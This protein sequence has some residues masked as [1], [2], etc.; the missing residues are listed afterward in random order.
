MLRSKLK[1]DAVYFFLLLPV[2]AGVGAIIYFS[3][4]FEPAWIPLLSMLCI[5]TILRIA[6]RKQFAAA[7]GVTLAIALLAGFVVGKWETERRATPMLGSDV[8]TRV[9][10]GLSLLNIRTMA[11]GG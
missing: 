1:R 2:F 10:V 7:Q 3:L 9:T 11:A 8:A 5:A 4:S 6:T